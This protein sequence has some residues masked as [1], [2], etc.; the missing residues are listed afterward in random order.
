MLFLSCS[1]KYGSPSSFNILCNLCFN[2]KMLVHIPPCYFS[3]HFDPH[4]SVLF[5]SCS[6]KYGSPSSFNILCS[7]FNFKMFVLSFKSIGSLHFFAVSFQLSLLLRHGIPSFKDVAT[8]LS[9]NLFIIAVENYP[10]SESGLS[11]HL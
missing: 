10:Q 1:V 7:M 11:W 8:V 3:M 2:F 4:P 5:L 6:V 9:M